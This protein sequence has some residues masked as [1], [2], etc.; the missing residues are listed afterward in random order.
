VASPKKSDGW[1]RGGRQQL[2]ERRCP[3]ARPR[4]RVEGVLKSRRK[5]MRLLLGRDEVGNASPFCQCHFSEQTRETAA[6][7]SC[8]ARSTAESWQLG[9][10]PKP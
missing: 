5:Q 7:T 6:H 9:F 4:R 10:R 1:R 2:R 8:L 3:R